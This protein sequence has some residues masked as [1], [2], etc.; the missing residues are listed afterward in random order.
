M[1]KAV[2]PENQWLGRVRGEK[3]RAGKTHKVKAGD[4]K[5]KCYHLPYLTQFT[6]LPL[7]HSNTFTT[8]LK[9]QPTPHP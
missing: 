5:T 3:A 6:C 2:D 7:P 1:E 9:P 8:S 4:D